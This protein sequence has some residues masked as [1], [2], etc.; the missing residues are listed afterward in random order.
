M[1][2]KHAWTRFLFENYELS[3]RQTNDFRWLS[4]GGC[5]IRVSCRILHN[6]NMLW[7][8]CWGGVPHQLR[9]KPHTVMFK[10]LLN[11]I[12]P[13]FQYVW[14]SIFAQIHILWYSR[15]QPELRWQLIPHRNATI[16]CGA[17]WHILG[18][19]ICLQDTKIWYN[20]KPY[21]PL[22]LSYF[23]NRDI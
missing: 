2:R 7:S 11:W 8:G 12:H 6:S 23:E 5:G 22:E 18:S 13:S 17:S 3:F 15:Y 9:K 20:C 19:R 4:I 21:L 14:S 10:R 1:W 16:V